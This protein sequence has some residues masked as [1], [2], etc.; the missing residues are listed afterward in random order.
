MLVGGPA[1]PKARI[2]SPTVPH[3]GHLY[4][5]VVAD[6]FARFQRLLEPTRPVHFL[7]GTDEH[8]L[9]IQQAALTKNLPPDIFC[10]QLSEQFRVCSYCVSAP[11]RT[12]LRMSDR[13]WQTGRR[14][15][16]PVSCG[17]RRS[18]TTKL[19]WT[20]GFVAMHSGLC[21]NNNTL[22]FPIFT[23]L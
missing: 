10:D 12:S 3:I 8:G 19:L 2:D 20:F 4:S 21:V 16:T 13:G 15:A 5:L 22:T 17:P 11:V 1:R 6:V 9:K 7:A 18:R 14:S 23:N